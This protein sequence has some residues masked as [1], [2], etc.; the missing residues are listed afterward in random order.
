MP[1]KKTKR[2]R[3]WESPAYVSFIHPFCIIRPDDEEDFT[4][5]LNDINQNTYNHAKLCRVVTALPTPQ[6]GATSLIVC[7]DGAIAVPAL[8]ALQSIEDVLAILNGA[9]CSVLLGGQLCDAVDSRDI[10]MGNL[11]ERR[12]IWPT[13]FGE[14]LN[15]HMHST[16]RMRLASTIDTILLADP[17]NVSVT[18]FL[19]TYKTGR[20]ILDK[21]PNLSPTL[22]MRGFTEMRYGNGVDA[23]SN[24]WIVVEQLTNL[25]WKKHFLDD[26][27]KHPIPGIPN[28]L[29]SLEQDTRTWATSVRHEILFQ[30][31]V[32]PPDTYAK[33]HSA[34]KARNDLVHEGRRPQE[35][36]VD[37]LFAGVLDL[38]QTASGLNPEQLRGMDLKTR[39]D[40][41]RRDTFD[42]TDWDHVTARIGS[43]S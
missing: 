8:P 22:L 3:S 18:Q 5:P 24:L 39:S 42:L 27:G 12:A 34:R 4:V 38:I 11:H 30:G 23:L 28:R 13:D 15:A 9:M 25:L 41:K 7:A 2:K 36:I 32:L 35:R 21:L 1:E 37:T 14:S 31:G 19:T 17:K 33:I 43:E 10:V 16:M 6:L 29:R 20:A 40:F 26:L